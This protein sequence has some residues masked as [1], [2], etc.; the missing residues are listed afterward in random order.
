MEPPIEEI[1]RILQK[2]NNEKAV[3]ETMK[4]L[5]D[6]RKI[7]INIAI[8]GESGAGKSTLVNV[9]RGVDHRAADAAPTGVKETTM[10]PTKYT[11]PHF[12]NVTVWDLPGVGTTRMPAEKYL[13]HVGFQK[14][15]FFF[16]VSNVRFTENDAN[17]AQE[18]QR[19]G[20]KFYFVRS[21]IDSDVYN[22]KR[23]LGKSEEETLKEIRSDCFKGLK[24][25][26]LRNPKVFL[27]SSLDL[28]LYDFQTLMD[29]LTAEMPDHK[30]NAVLLAVPVFN[31]EII[32]KK[33]ESL[34]GQIAGLN[35]VSIV[36]ALV[37]F[38]GVSAKIDDAIL[39]AFV[40]DCKMSLGLTEE[41]LQSLSL[42]SNVPVSE[43]KEV[44]KL[45]VDEEDLVYTIFTVLLPPV[46]IFSGGIA[47]KLY[48]IL[49]TFAED[50]QKVFKRALNP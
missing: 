32:E 17:L 8:T 48:H 2:G 30:R 37:P 7:P 33:K 41:N 26:G 13:E 19:M 22:A 25:L 5:K 24:E 1:K 4:L 38:P 23:S 40:H 46:K 47:P 10:E 27:I 28:H 21:K 12:P 50:A 34:S 6:W 11:H 43:L 39:K 29:T 20:K 18:I 35:A 44:M 14:Y 31:R 45:P 15:E 36:A 42:V 9:L 49:D 16:I 3:A